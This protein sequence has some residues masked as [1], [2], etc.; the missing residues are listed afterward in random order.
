MTGIW[1]KILEKALGTFILT[2]A[3]IMVSPAIAITIMWFT[4]PL[5]ALLGWLFGIGFW[6]TF[7][8]LEITMV[9]FYGIDL[10]SRSD[11]DD[12]EPP[13]RRVNMPGR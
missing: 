13:P 8:M 3:F 10:L 7:A 9:V 2:A 11:D 4:L 5:A 1:Q 6:K 12:E